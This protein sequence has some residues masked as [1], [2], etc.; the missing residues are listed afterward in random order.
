MYGYGRF[1]YNRFGGLYRKYSRYGRPSYRRRRTYGAV[2]APRLRRKVYPTRYQRK[3]LTRYCA[4]K[5]HYTLQANPA[6]GDLLAVP[7][8]GW[9][10]VSYPGLQ[11]QSRTRF[12]RTSATKRIL[13]Y[14]GITGSSFRF[15]SEEE[16][17]KVTALVDAMMASIAAVSQAQGPEVAQA[18]FATPASKRV[19]G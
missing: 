18:M 5:R 9:V 17:L 2:L 6:T 1:R 15:N 8:K 19:R 10:L 16:R 11:G 13:K 12:L 14:R 4:G 3:R 7:K